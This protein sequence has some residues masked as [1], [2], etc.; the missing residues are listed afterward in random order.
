MGEPKAVTFKEV[1][2]V[3]GEGIHAATE[4]WHK[5]G[6]IV[7]AGHVGLDPDGN[8]SID[9]TEVS[10]SKRERIDKILNPEPQDADVVIDE[11][12]DLSKMS[13]AD[14]EKEAKSV[15]LDGNAYTNKSEL[16]EA[17]NQKRGK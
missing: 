16:I 7:G 1:K 17:I 11:S 15:G 4:L 3:A 5:V 6:D 13:R 14:L 8:A 2:K 10:D 9:L 12:K